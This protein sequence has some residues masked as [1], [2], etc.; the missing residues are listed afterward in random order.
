MNLQADG[1]EKV[2]KS[3]GKLADS[4]S[5]NSKTA[6]I[7]AV[8]AIFIAGGSFFFSLIDYCTDKQWQKD[9]IIELKAIKQELKNLNK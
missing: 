2:I 5:K 8:I 1:S 9:Q 3:I 7:I 6:L 4:S